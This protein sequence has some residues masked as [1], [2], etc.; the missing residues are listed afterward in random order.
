MR[1]ARWLKFLADGK[2]KRGET[3]AF[4]IEIFGRPSTCAPGRYFNYNTTPA[5]CQEKKAKKIN[6]LFIPKGI[7]KIQ[8]LCY[9]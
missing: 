8:R 1:F 4:P 5:I 7:D 3:L 9:N 6:K 2:S